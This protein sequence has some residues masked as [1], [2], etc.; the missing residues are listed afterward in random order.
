MLGL[1][2]SR[3]AFPRARACTR[4][5]ECCAWGAGERTTRRVDVRRR[6]PRWADRL[7]HWP[8]GPAAAVS[9]TERSIQFASP[10]LVEIF[11]FFE[12]NSLLSLRNSLFL[13]LI[14]IS[15]PTRL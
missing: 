5:R 2:E 1:I 8:S 6:G 12:K 3:L 4:A 10:V 15:E 9:R 7:D 11:L 14:H 13:S